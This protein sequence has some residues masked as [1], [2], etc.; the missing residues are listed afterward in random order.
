M[1]NQFVA[2]GRR[3]LADGRNDKRI[4][5]ARAKYADEWVEAGFLKRIKLRFQI[6]RQALSQKHGHNPAPGTLW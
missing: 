3:R 1:K 6:W 5:A 2:D 4:E